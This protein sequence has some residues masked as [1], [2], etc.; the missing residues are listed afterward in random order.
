MK[1]LTVIFICALTSACAEK[2]MSELDYG[3]RLALANVI[4]SKC[5][6][7]GLTETSPAWG[8][9]VNAEIQAEDARRQA[10][11]RNRHLMAGALMAGSMQMS[12]AYY[13]AAATYRPP[14]TCNTVRG[15][16]GSMTTQCQ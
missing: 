11:A 7:L 6:S 1:P 14:I 16:G 2:Q 12:N 10:D 8:S 9:C 3:E 4:I 5:Q 13:G 15:Y